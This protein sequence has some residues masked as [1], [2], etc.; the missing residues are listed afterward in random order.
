MTGP[1]SV[2]QILTVDDHPLLREGIAA[3]VSTQSDM[4][5]VSEAANGHEAI[6]QFR[7]AGATVL[8][9]GAPRFNEFVVR[10]KADPYVINDRL[11]ERHILGGFPVLKKFYP[12]LGDGHFAL[13]CCTELVSR[14]AIE[15]AAAV[16]AG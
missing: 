13:W 10:T 2:I 11:I 16:L 1:S 5:L 15:S 12:E 6:E 7:K 8:F 3:L 4:K 9:D 14:E